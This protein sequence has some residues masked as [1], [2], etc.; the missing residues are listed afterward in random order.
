MNDTLSIDLTLPF[1]TSNNA[2]IK[3]LS[4]TS[5]APILIYGALWSSADSTSFYNFGG[6]VSSSAHIDDPPV[7]IWQYTPSTVG[8]N[9]ASVPRSNSPQSPTLA[10]VRPTCAFSAY[11]NGRGYMLG[12]Y[13][14]AVTHSYLTTPVPGMLIYNMTANTWLNESAE[15]YSAYGTALNGRMHF[16]PSYGSS[17]I[18]AIFGG[19]FSSP[20]SWLEE[21]NNHVPFSNITLYDTATN[22]WYWQTATGAT[23]SNDVPPPA[24]MFC[25]AVASASGSGTIEI[26]MYGGHSDAFV[27]WANGNEPNSSQ[28]AAQAIFNVVYVLSIPGFVWF[29]SSDTSAPSRSGHSCERIGNRQMLSIGGLDPTIG[30]HDPNSATNPWNKTDPWNQTLGVFDMTSLVWTGSYDPQAPPYELPQVVRDWYIQP[31]TNS[32]V[33]WTSQATRSLF[34]PSDTTN[35]TANGTAVNGTAANGTTTNGPSSPSTTPSTTTSSYSLPGGIIAG[36]VIACAAGLALLVATGYFARRWRRRQTQ[37]PMNT[38]MPGDEINR[39]SRVL[40]SEVYDRVEMAETNAAH[41]RH[42][43]EGHTPAIE[44]ADRDLTRSGHVFELSGGVGRR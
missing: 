38:R 40:P 36:V 7:D 31:S 24:T 15:E 14:G 13:D 35:T 43:I 41:S 26:F 44:L 9:Y 21:G 30:W 33:N 34:F 3:K 18:L 19:E 27:E 23:G 8:L 5:K 20:T 25:S 2:Q 42:E 1:Y 10:G 29:K 39:D 16:L 17:G 6:V 11:G 22:E 4:K 32:S 12:G 28:E 37:G